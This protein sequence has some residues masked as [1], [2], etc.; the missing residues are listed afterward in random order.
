M[1][2]AL[3]WFW[4]FQDTPYVILEIKNQEMLSKRKEAKSA[5]GSQKKGGEIKKMCSQKT[6]S[7]LE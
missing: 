7:E 4:D 3:E 6:W 2:V 1:N 5:K